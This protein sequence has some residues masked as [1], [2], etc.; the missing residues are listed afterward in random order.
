MLQ[1]LL[2]I[3]SAFIGL[4][5][6]LLVIAIHLNN[7]RNLPPGPWNLPII[8][9][10]PWLDPKSPYLTLTELSQKY[11]AIYG[12]YLGSVYTVVLSDAKLVKKTLMRDETS[13]RAPLHLTHGIMHGYG[14]KNAS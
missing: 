6:V 11:G 13:G 8:G 5:A 10:L 3:L 4:L 12:V 2:V 9:Y 1:M 7:N 14:K